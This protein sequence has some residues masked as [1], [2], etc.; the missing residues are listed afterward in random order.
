M[1]A[2]NSLKKESP[3]FAR[4][5][6]LHMP[7]NKG[8]SFRCWTA[9]GYAVLSLLF[10]LNK[11]FCGAFERNEIEIAARSHVQS[12]LVIAVTFYTAEIDRYS[13]TTAI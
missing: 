8:P 4:Y 3:E 6:I 2:Q 7:I 13:L 5:G 9:L 10:P 12:Y 1:N 11:E